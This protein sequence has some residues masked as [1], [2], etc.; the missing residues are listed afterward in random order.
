MIRKNTMK[1]FTWICLTACLLFWGCAAVGP[2]YAP[3]SPAAPERWN[4]Q[5]DTASSPGSESVQSFVQWWTVFD[6]PVLTDLVEQAVQSNTDVRKARARVL[7]ARARR[8]KERIGTVSRSRRLGFGDLQ[9]HPTVLRRMAARRVI[10]A[11]FRCGMGTGSLRRRAPFRRG[12]AGGS[13]VGPGSLND[14]WVSLAGEVALQLRG[15]ENPARRG[16]DRPKPV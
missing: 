4:N 2:D 9:R 1:P 8:G 15:S 7:E 6:D 14:A 16:F 13:G 12:G 5:P 10:H 11:G 3:P